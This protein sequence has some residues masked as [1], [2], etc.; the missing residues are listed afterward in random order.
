MADYPFKINIVTKNGTKISHFDEDFASDSDTL[1]SA[2]AIVTRINNMGTGASYVESIENVGEGSPSYG[3]TGGSVYLSASYTHPNTGSIVFTDTETTTNGG[4]D[5]YVFHGAKVCSVLGLPEGI[6]IYTENF[7]LSDSSTDTTNYVSGEF[8]SDRVALKKGFKMSPQARM[9]SNLI[10]DEVFGEG[11]LQWVSGSNVKMTIG[12]DNLNNRYEVQAPTGSFSLSNISKGTVTTL[13]TGAIEVTNNNVRINNNG[14]SGVI[15]FQ[16]PS[17]SNPVT[18]RFNNNSTLDG[19][20]FNSANIHLNNNKIYF[21]T[22]GY[23]TYIQET[24]NDVLDFYVGNVNMLKLDEGNETTTF[25]GTGSF[26]HIKATKRSI[27]GNTSVGTANA[28]HQFYGLGGVYTTHFAMYDEDGEEIMRASGR[29]ASNTLKFEFGDVAGAANGTIYTVDDGNTKHVFDGGFVDITT[30]TD[31]TD[32]TGDTG[33]LRVEGGASIAKKVYIGTDLHVGGSVIHDGDTD[34]KMTFGTNDISFFTAGSERM[35]IESGGDIG[36]GTTNPQ[37]KLEVNDN[38]TGGNQPV[39]QIHN[40]SGTDTSIREHLE[41]RSGDNTLN[42]DTRWV[43]FRNNSGTFVGGISND[44]V[45]YGSFTG[46]HMSQNNLTDAQI[47]GSWIS[48]MI[49]K[50]NGNIIGSGSSLSEALPEVEPTTT[51]K[52]KAVMGVYTHVSPPDQWRDMDNSKGAIFYNSIGE[53]R[54]LVTDTNGD[55]E[56]GDYICSSN[57][58]GHG[59]KQDDDLLHNYTVAKATEPIDFSTIS[60]DSDLGYKS[61]LVACTYHCG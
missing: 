2:S 1:I 54:V 34:T 18:V 47:T 55:I 42:S 25:F 38:V 23:H 4:L 48:G 11:M 60:V 17:S 45:S 43:T 16:G 13:T 52:D 5:Y 57:R 14:L 31:A 22:G 46:F 40:T 19:I 29:A 35:V 26:S 33:A 10:W 12:Y 24:S 20:E 56:T 27:F 49:V 44:P 37:Y 9:Q 51:Q 32:S 30:T 8:I 41:I 53:G 28:A 3:S 36:I 15:R 61:V 58:E 39:V 7:K 21:D 6:R 59:E 50:S